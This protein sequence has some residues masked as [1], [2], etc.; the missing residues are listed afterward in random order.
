[1]FPSYW[2]ENV[3]GIIADKLGFRVLFIFVGVI[4]L[5]GLVVQISLYS[6]VIELDNH[7]LDHSHD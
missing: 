4:S 5:I 6:T 2:I 1:V 7:E 3:G